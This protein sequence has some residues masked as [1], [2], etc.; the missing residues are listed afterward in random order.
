MVSKRGTFGKVGRYFLETQL[1]AGMAIR[2][3]QRSMRPVLNS[4]DCLA[5]AIGLMLRSD[6][7]RMYIPITT[8]EVRSVAA[9][10]VHVL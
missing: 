3:V 8:T 10:P 6:L 5:R 2:I 4:R 9:I 7:E 1:K